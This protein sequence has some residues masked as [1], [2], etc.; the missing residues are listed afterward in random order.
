MAWKESSD[1]ILLEPDLL[2]EE[3]LPK[4]II[5]R[6]SQVSLLRSCLAPILKN[7]KPLHS[8]L[9]GR[10][11]TGKTA[12]AKSLAHEIQTKSNVQYI[13]V[14]CRKYNSFYSILDHVLNELRV[15][16][17][18]DR[19]G[20]VK[21]EK[22]ER[23]IR[24]RPFLIILDEIDF[25]PQKERISLLYNLSFGKVG[26]VCISENREALISL[27]GRVKSRLQPHL[28]EFGTYTPAE[29]GDIL[30]Q[31]AFA[32]LAPGSWSPKVLEKIAYLAQGDAR[33][34][35]QTL[36]GAAELA[37]AQGATVIGED[38]I[39]GASTNITDIK[40]SYLLKKLGDHYKTLYSLIEKQGSKGV[41]STS[42][43]ELYRAE[44]RKRV[45][46]PVAKRTYSYYLNKMTRLSLV[47]ARMARLRGHVYSFSVRGEG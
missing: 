8:W 44:C 29:I 19:D 10:P 13:Y 39:K 12:A 46:E 15:G 32:A 1:A 38:H 18:N 42:L 40:K 4:D 26:L 37:Q 45:L 30:Q 17:G 24:D 35:I 28:I 41:L 31:R 33:A 20:R 25:L 21:L 7:E 23:H 2:S 14:N 22:I 6:E 47:E 9:H 5:G 16:F 43:W 36:R 3:H 11:G 27:N 34:A